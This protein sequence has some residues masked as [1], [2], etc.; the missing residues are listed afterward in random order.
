MKGVPTLI[1]TES[2]NMT[3]WPQFEQTVR[4]RGCRLL[5]RLGDF[6]QA[7]LVAGCHQSGTMILSRIMTQ[8]DRTVN[9]WFGTDGE[10]ATALILSK[11]MEPEFHVQ[12]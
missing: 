1:C 4:A 10:L 5:R 7:I 8:S 2:M 6:L 11:Y 3:T 9:C 12:F